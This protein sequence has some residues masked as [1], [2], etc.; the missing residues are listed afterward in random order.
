MLNAKQNNSR[1]ETF[2]LQV[3]Q[4]I[5]VRTYRL[6]SKQSQLVCYKINL[7]VSPGKCLIKLCLCQ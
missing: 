5:V 7:Y 6:V 1:E 2:L 3:I 4:L